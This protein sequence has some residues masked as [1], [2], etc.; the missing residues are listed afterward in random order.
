MVPYTPRERFARTMA[1]QEADRVPLDLAGTAL[2]SADR[3][4]WP[5]L[6]SAL[7]IQG[8]P[9]GDPSR[10]ERVLRALDVDFRRVGA[11]IGGGSKPVP[12][13]PD[14]QVD[15]WGVVRAWTGKYWDIVHS[16]LRDATIEDLDAYP[17][18]DPA[19]IAAEAPLERFQSEARRLW[20]ETGY[21]VVAEHPVY[22][23]FEL[24]CWMCGFDD[25]LYRLAGDQEFVHHFFVKY[26][27]IQKAIIRPYYQALGP[28]IHLTS[29][30]DDFGTQTGP[31]LAPRAFRELIKPYFAERIAYTREFTS[32]YFWHHTCGSVVKLLPDLIEA[33]VDILNPV[34]PGALGMEPAS[35]KAAF[36]DQICFHG[37]FDTQGVLPFGTLEE[38]ESEVQRVMGALKPNGGYIFSAA[39][40]IQSDV[41]AA[42]IVT[43]FQAAKRLGVY[44]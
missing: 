20:E 30:G 38:I 44:A 12:G 9:E 5:A 36:G 15:M 14:R 32:G 1:H 11:L 17:W 19:Q 28:Y 23:V 29:S 10:D 37:G 42:N 21:V 13:Y 2:T 18:P 3:D 43:M 7:G 26:L 39:H 4:V 8:E 41:P 35:L 16:P 25:F 33:G 34:Q 24:A 40:N 6:R 22:G 31:F 27:Q